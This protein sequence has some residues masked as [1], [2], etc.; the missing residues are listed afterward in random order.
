MEEREAVARAK[1]YAQEAR[2]H[3]LIVGLVDVHLGEDVF[4]LPIHLEEASAS[5]E[6]RY[7]LP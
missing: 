4:R 2:R 1:M 7:V 5:E 6:L 3:Q